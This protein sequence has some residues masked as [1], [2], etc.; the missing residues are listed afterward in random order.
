MDRIGADFFAVLEEIRTKLNAVP[1]ALQIPIGAEDHFEGV[2]DLIQQKALYWKDENGETIIEKEI[3]LN[4]QIEADE[5]RIKLQET[6]A[7]YN[8]DFFEYFM[9]TEFRISNEMMVKAIQE[10]CRSG[11]AVPVLCGSAFKNKGI[12]PLLDA[13]VTYLPAPDQLA[14]IQGKILRQKKSLNWEEMRLK[15]FR[16]GLQSH[17]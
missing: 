17:Y 2:I 8:E 1:L 5:Y 15:L 12:Q 14:N 16:A 10:I 9:D 13:V 7:E 6:L 11:A 4:Y 3:P